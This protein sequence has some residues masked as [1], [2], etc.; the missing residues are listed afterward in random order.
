MY[1]AITLA[2]GQLGDPAFRSVLLKALALT[3]V[4]FFLLGVGATTVF[5]SYV[6]NFQ[7]EW[8]NTV[9]SAL[10]GLGFVVGGF[11]LF[12]LVISALIGLFLDD[13]SDAVEEKHYPNDEKAHDVPIMSSIWDAVKFLAVIIICNIIVLPLYFIPVINLFVYYIL[14]GYLI[15]RE[16][17]Q[18]VAIRHHDV[19]DVTR[20]R[21]SKSTELFILGVII[22]FCLT[23]PI[24]NLITPIVATAAMVHLYKKRVGSKSVSLVP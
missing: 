3:V 15:S 12:P 4:I 22:A 6:P 18:M 13:I 16:Y 24:V 9:L 10:T 1:S 19:D 14:N 7:W 11:F 5:S 21:K 8:V 17:F 23:I 20:L 2:I